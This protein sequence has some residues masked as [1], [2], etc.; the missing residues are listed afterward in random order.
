[1][2]DLLTRLLALAELAV[3]EALELEYGDPE[4]RHIYRE[5]QELKPLVATALSQPEPEGP[6]D[7]EME[8]APFLYAPCWY[9]NDMAAAW[10]AGRNSGWCDALARFARPALK[11]VPVSESSPGEGDLD[12]E[13]ACWMWHPVNFHYCLCRPDPSVHTHWL[14]HHALPVPLP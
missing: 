9:N 1:M 10:E 8:E 5:L 12:H 14:P 13:G 2:T 3:S 4:D 11:P 6:T 7:E